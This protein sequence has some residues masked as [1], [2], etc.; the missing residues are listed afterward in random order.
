M[1]RA[2]DN[3]DA[4]LTL[5]SAL[6]SH[7]PFIFKNCLDKHDAA[8]LTAI[9]ATGAAS[10]QR[11]EMTTFLNVENDVIIQCG[12]KTPMWTVVHRTAELRLLDSWY[13]STA[14][15]SLDM[16]HHSG[17][18]SNWEVTWRGGDVTQLEHWRAEQ[19]QWRR[20]LFA[21]RLVHWLEV[22]WRVMPQTTRLLYLWSWH[23]TRYSII[24]HWH[25]KNRLCSAVLT[26][27]LFLFCAV[28]VIY[29]Y[30]L[31]TRSRPILFET[32]TDR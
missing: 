24:A 4:M 13:W 5:S 23:V 29:I 12:R 26:D 10:C 27:R 11:A 20:E 32:K 28:N 25:H 14:W 6:W 30:L 18:S 15:R 22:E 2:L 21:A 3:A 31:I 1:V 9:C 7:L 16:E 19:Q 8:T 17:S